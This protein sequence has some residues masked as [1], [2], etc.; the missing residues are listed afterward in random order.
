MVCT[1]IT[2]TEPPVDIT[3]VQA[4]F[5]RSSL[6][7]RTYLNSDCQVPYLDIN[8]TKEAVM[9]GIAF[10]NRLFLSKTVRVTANFTRPD[11]SV[12]VLSGNAT[13]IGPDI[14]G[15]ETVYLEGI[16]NYQIGTYSGLT[17]TAATV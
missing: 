2:V 3:V 9:V 11:G 12:A 15:G 6:G 4:G 8:N 10:S 14:V 17:A 1:T 13:F 7:V 5:A 16:Q